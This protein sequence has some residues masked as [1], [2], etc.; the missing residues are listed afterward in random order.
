MMAIFDYETREIEEL[1]LEWWWFK[2][3]YFSNLEIWNL[4]GFIYPP[5][6]LYPLLYIMSGSLN[7]IYSDQPYFVLELFFIEGLEPFEFNQF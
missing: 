7:K 1:K 3:V 6:I 5:N 4:F 2:N